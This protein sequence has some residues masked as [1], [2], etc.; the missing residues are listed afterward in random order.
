M[1]RYLVSTVLVCRNIMTTT[2]L[3]SGIFHYLPNYIRLVL[4][5]I[6]RTVYNV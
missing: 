4:N 6:R 5:K 2:N 1:G 3:E